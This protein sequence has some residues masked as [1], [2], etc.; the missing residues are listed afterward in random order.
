MDKYDHYKER[1]MK[2]IENEPE[3]FKDAVR[4]IQQD[5]VTAI[6]HHIDRFETLVKLNNFIPR[7]ISISSNF[8]N[9][10]NTVSHSVELT[11]NMAS[12]RFPSYISVDYLDNVLAKINE[13]CS[14][15]IINGNLDTKFNNVFELTFNDLE[16][17]SIF[18]N[19]RTFYIDDENNEWVTHSKYPIWKKW[20]DPYIKNSSIDYFNFCELSYLKEKT[21]I[22]SLIDESDPIK[23][24]DNYLKNKEH[25]FQILNMINIG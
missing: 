4:I 10:N 25:Y 21:L 20:I 19:F 5:S 2:L 12:Q 13:F 16:L 3:L 9:L 8:N 14:I 6:D 15:G 1:V 23:E 7:D 17:V 18:Q 22:H 11:F 24:L